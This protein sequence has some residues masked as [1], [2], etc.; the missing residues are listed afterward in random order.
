MMTENR[1]IR[2]LRF[3]EYFRKILSN[4]YEQNFYNI[5]VLF[6][7]FFEAKL[8]GDI[9]YII[10]LCMSTGFSLFASFYLELKFN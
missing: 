6:Y 4:L 7:I 3:L 1:E 10:Y 9:F 5:L 2:Y 8:I